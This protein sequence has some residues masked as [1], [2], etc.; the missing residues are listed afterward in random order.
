MP[1]RLLRTPARRPRPHP[2]W[3]LCCGALTSWSPPFV[4]WTPRTPRCS[5]GP[6]WR[7]LRLKKPASEPGPLPGRRKWRTHRRRQLYRRRQKRL[8]KRRRHAPKTRQCRGR[9]S[10]C[11]SSSRQLL[12]PRVVLDRYPLWGTAEPRLP[13]RATRPTRQWLTHG[14]Q[15]TMKRLVVCRALIVG[16]E[17]P[18][19]TFRCRPALLT[20]HHNQLAALRRLRPQSV[21][22]AVLQLWYRRHPHPESV[23]GR[24]RC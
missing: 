15:C 20:R 17:R 12:L 7:V 11:S 16:D 6:S 5:S 18:R 1:S 3:L 10:T 19:R 8:R 9:E 4:E 14:V 23:V 2:P 21:V 13:V 22:Y 24:M